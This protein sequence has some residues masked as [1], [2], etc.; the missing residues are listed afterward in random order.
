M[1]AAFFRACLLDEINHLVEVIIRLPIGNI[2]F[3]RRTVVFISRGS[4]LTNLTRKCIVIIVIKSRFSMTMLFSFCS[5]SEI[6]FSESWRAVRDHGRIH[7]VAQMGYLCITAVFI[8]VSKWTMQELWPGEILVKC[9]REKKNASES[10]E[11]FFGKINC[12][13]NNLYEIL[14]RKILIRFFILVKISYCFIMC[15]KF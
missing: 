1:I 8:Y 4:Y 12:A 14:K 10:I 3:S 9:V 13:R 6:L 11:R 15:F 7:P 5:L 2:N